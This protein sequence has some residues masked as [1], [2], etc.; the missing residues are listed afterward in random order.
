MDIGAV[1]SFPATRPTAPRTA[2]SAPSG[3]PADAVSSGDDGIVY[4]SPAIKYDQTAR[5]AVLLFRDA[6]T[7]ETKDQ[8]PSEHV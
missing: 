2:P 4:V 1:S 5:M 3:R 7:G 6:D 8:I